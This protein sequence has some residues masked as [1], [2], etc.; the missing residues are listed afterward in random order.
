VLFDSLL[1]ALRR[2]A[3]EN[4]ANRVKGRVPAPRV[5]IPSA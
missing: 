3:A 1:S 5:S 2:L 4:Q